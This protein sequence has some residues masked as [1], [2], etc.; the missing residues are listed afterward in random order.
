MKKILCLGILLCTFFTQVKA[1]QKP[2][3]N[4]YMLNG[5]LLNPALTGVENY[6]DVK[7]SF[8]RQWTGLEGSPNSFYLTAHS[9]LDKIDRSSSIVSLPARGKSTIINSLR[10]QEAADF[11]ALKPHK[12]IGG[13]L[14]SD[15]MGPFT[16]LGM[17][18][19]YAYHMPVW[20]RKM[21]L[22]AGISGGFTRFA[23]DYSRLDFGSI[24]DPVVGQY[25]NATLLPEIGVGVML[26]GKNFYGGASASQLFQNALNFNDT[27]PNNQ[28]QFS[29]H[30]FLMGGYEYRLSKQVSIMPSILVKYVQPS[31][32][33][34]DLNLKVAY[35]RKVWGGLSYRHQ[36]ALAAL[37]GVNVNSLVNV[38]YAYEVA[39]STLSTYNGGSHELMLGVILNNTY[40]VKSPL[41]FKL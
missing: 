5:Y 10:L 23:V 29:N 19:S 3:Y 13:I 33:S 35:L 41:Q 14:V 20:R 17:S 40:K 34:V 38:G 36:N 27:N 32:V 22:S 12:G 28:Q 16:R 7:T 15:A 2:Q 11:K 9:P 37:A 26:Y 24:S 30:Y 6:L 18:L 8:R 4:Q 39:T 1:Q 21:K 25:R 31:P